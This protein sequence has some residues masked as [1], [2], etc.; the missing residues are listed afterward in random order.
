M[1]RIGVDTG[2]TFTD[3]AVFGPSGMRVHKLPSTPSDPATAVVDGLT[4]V[5]GGQAVDVVHGTTVGLNAI[6]T[7]AVARTAFVTNSGFEDLI[8]I[9]R[10][11]RSSVY[12][13]TARRAVLPVPRGR[14]FAVSSRRAASGE[15]L[16]Q[17]DTVELEELLRK[18]RR[19]RVG[20]VAIGLLHSYAH[21]EDEHEIARAL[22]PL[23]V[24]VTCSA[25]LLP[26]HGE[27]ERF[28]AAILNAAICPIVSAYLE[29]L[30]PAVAPGSLRLMRSS[31]GVMSTPEAKEYP[32][33]A[34]LSG[35]AG[36]VLACNQLARALGLDTVA[37]L[38]MGGTSA[39]VSLVTPDAPPSS[40]RTIAG[41]PLEVPAVEVHTIGCGGGSLATRDA[42]GALRVGPESAGADP[43]PACYGRGEHPTVTDAHM[44]LGHMGAETLLGGDFPVDPEL[45]VRAV[46]RLGKSLGMSLRKTAEGILEIADVAMMRALLVIT[47]ERAIDPAGVPLIA[48]GGAGG[49]HAASLMRR[50]S[51]PQAI[52]PQHPGAFSAVGL[53]LASESHEETTPVLREVGE[54]SPREL[55][56]LATELGKRAR[57]ALDGRGRSVTKI[58]ARLRYR[59]QGAGLWVPFAPALAPAF[60]EAHVRLYGFAPDGAAVE[61][62]ELRARAERSPRDLP[63]P[64]SSRGHG[65]PEPAFLRAAPTGGRRW[66]VFRRN[67]LRSGAQL[68]GP[69]LIEE[70]TG[71]TV[72]PPD[73]TCLVKQ[74]ALVLRHNP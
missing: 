29:R 27:Y 68:R 55:R 50:L 8:E 60:R 26:V 36:G 40:Q 64:S 41:L 30:E 10:Q 49:L 21:P 34:A 13:L 12:D 59:G 51:M 31:G 44:V 47:V 74:A 15:R 71:A 62:V 43:G 20:A 69:C 6:L 52:V 56:A 37:A 23:G 3:V 32:A 73:T 33:R 16:A 58:E 45:S 70:A 39:D 24:P 67:E 54:V 4:A 35:P 17:P 9:G 46:G 5:R 57:Q 48:F 28:A 61:L 14:R 19:A 53:A 2:G 63:A 18:L 38:D 66:K 22:A 65:Q 1:L 42:G 7:G 11:I 72:V 25:D